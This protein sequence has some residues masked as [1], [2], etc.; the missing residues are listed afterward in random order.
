MEIAYK[1][2][3]EL[4][5]FIQEHEDFM[6]KCPLHAIPVKAL[7]DWTKEEH[8]TEACIGLMNRNWKCLILL[9]VESPGMKNAIDELTDVVQEKR[10]L[11]VYDTANSTFDLLG[12]RACTRVTFKKLLGLYS[13]AISIADQLHIH[14]PTIIVVEQNE[15]PGSRGQRHTIL[16]DN[17]NPKGDIVKIV[18]QG[19]AKMLHTLAHEMR[20]CW[21]EY[22]TD[23]FY[24]D[25]KDFSEIGLSYMNQIEEIDADAYASC[26]LD[27]LG[28]NGINYCVEVDEIGAFDDYLKK[29]SLRM[30]QLNKS[31]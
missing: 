1:E 24:K 18:L 10:K 23:Y 19:K 25:Y 4:Y 12:I 26:Y 30:S 13:A 16:D 14:V 31:F 5:H 7:P 9:V 27:S 6:S 15:C 28:Y 11:V 17:D 2:T 22:K 29:V 21:Q 3:A 8:R 20:H